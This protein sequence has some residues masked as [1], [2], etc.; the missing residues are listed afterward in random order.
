M[1]SLGELGRFF[2]LYESAMFNLSEYPPVSSI[3]TIWLNKL[4]ANRFEI[5]KTISLGGMGAIFLAFDNNLHKTVV[6]KTPLVKD[7]S[8]KAEINGRFFREVYCL[9][10][11]EHPFI[12]PII[13]TGVHETQPF[14]V[15]RFINGGNL[16]DLIS[17][18][19]LHHKTLSHESLYDWVPKI[20]A[21]LSFMHDN[22]WVH[23]DIKPDNILFDTNRNCYLT[24]FGISKHLIFDPINCLTTVNSIL[25]SPMYM[26]PEQHLGHKPTPKCDQYS[27][28]VVIYEALSN[29][30]PFN[31]RTQS[32]IL[33]EIIRQNSVPLT[34]RY[35]N[36]LVSDHFNNSIMKALHFD[37]DH[38]H[39]SVDIFISELFKYSNH[40][41][42]SNGFHK[43][44]HVALHSTNGHTHSSPTP[45]KNTKHN[46]DTMSSTSFFNGM[47][48]EMTKICDRILSEQIYLKP[49]QLTKLLNLLIASEVFDKHKCKEI[50]ET[51]E[52]IFLL[53]SNKTDA[54]IL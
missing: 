51:L 8:L 10:A 11:L 19:F 15:S 40:E 26:A 36:S 53:E 18:A 31:G 24:D 32:A 27:L 37:P 50:I 14:I 21:A 2:E 1:A 39:D 35:T 6:L 34:S 48:N 52:F 7:A 28:A 9:T 4:I 33:L 25:G 23:R 30:L 16:R 45:I 5:L 43:N 46:T 20:G 38:R 13:Y 47:K 44:H 49:E 42:E 54:G 41:Q 17:D 22:D 29:K 12:V 3:E